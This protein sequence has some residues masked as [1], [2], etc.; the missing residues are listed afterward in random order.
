L[1]RGLAFGRELQPIRISSDRS[2]SSTACAKPRSR[3]NLRGPLKNGRSALSIGQHHVISPRPRKSEEPESPKARRYI[4]N[5]T[6]YEALGE[7]MSD[8]PNGVLAFRDELVSLLKG[9]DREEQAGARGFFLTAWNGTAGYTFDRIIRERL[10]SRR[11]VYP[12]LAQLNRA[13]LPS[14]FGARLPAAREK[15]WRTFDRLVGLD[16]GAIGV[17]RDQYDALPFLRFDGEAQGVF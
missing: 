4:V 13:G 1:K 10:I 14:M 8:N 5:D 11:R 12:C 15:A 17:E 9:L 16:A 6:T 3:K 2:T 7:I